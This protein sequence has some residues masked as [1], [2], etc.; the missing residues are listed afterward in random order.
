[1]AKDECNSPQSAALLCNKIIPVI[2]DATPVLHHDEANAARLRH[3]VSSRL[4]SV[5]NAPATRRSGSRDAPWQ[6]HVRHEHSDKG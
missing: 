1:M 2:A 4:A 5:R 6:N 3:P